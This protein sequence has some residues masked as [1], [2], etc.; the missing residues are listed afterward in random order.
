M[1]CQLG[2]IQRSRWTFKLAYLI[3][4]RWCSIVHSGKR[5]YPEIKEAA[6]S[7]F[8]ISHLFIIF[9]WEIPL[10]YLFLFD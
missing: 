8:R 7:V 10:F 9:N 3:V 2:N 1:V 6:V 4:S 5:F